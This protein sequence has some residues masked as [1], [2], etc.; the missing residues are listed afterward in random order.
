[1]HWMKN[2]RDWPIS[3]Q[4]WWGHRIPVYYAEDDRFTAARS[5]EEAR[6]KLG[7]SDEAPLRQD[8]DVL[9]TW[10]SS[11]LWPFS[12]HGWGS[13][14]KNQTDLATFYPTDLL[15][16]GPDIIFFW[17]ARMIMAGFAFM[18]G[19]EG[20]DG[21]PRSRPSDQIP[22]RH[23]YFTS[24]IRDEKGLK[25]SKSLGNSPDPLKVIEKY[26][27]DALRFTILYLAPTG[28]DIRFSEEACEIGRNFA[29]KIWNA[30]RFLMMKA[31]ETG[32]DRGGSSP[33]FSS[34]LSDLVPV[35]PSDYWILSRFHSALLDIGK[36]PGG[37][38]DQRLRQEDL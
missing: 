38:P 24:I 23:V 22:F 25:L 11:W 29:N 19:E 8:E 6:T 12:V 15:V 13:D 32:L 26:G 9:D 35:T 28:Q 21:E 1:M 10:F 7:L 18:E 4:L 14:Q 37:V 20:P 5:E 2:I 36:E 34:D 30:G 3:R 33:A 17:V 16:T 31:E 27:A